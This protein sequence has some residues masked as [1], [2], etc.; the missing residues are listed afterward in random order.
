MWPYISLEDLSKTKTLILMLHY[1][2]R[3]Q[4]HEF[5]HSDLE[6]AAFGERSGAMVPRFLKGYTM[7]FVGRDSPETYGELVS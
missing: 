5:V 3:Y 7:L 4:P 2:G 6:Q 1:R